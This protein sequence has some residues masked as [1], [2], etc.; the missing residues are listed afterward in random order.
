[1]SD[2][3]KM[4]G[5]RLDFELLDNVQQFDVAGGHVVADKRVNY[6]YNALSQVTYINRF[7]NLTGGNGAALRTRPLR[8]RPKGATHRLPPIAH[9]IEV[10]VK[11]TH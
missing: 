8:T 6:V 11:L 1:M 2:V 9:P 5:T 7:H 10:L 3:E 4:S